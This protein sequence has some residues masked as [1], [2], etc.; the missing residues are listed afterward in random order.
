MG[1]ES[2]GSSGGLCT[3]QTASQAAAPRC[4][5]THRQPSP[6]KEDFARLGEGVLASAPVG[7][8]THPRF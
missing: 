7:H 1:T 8:V 6:D 2:T 4:P 5:L 3:S